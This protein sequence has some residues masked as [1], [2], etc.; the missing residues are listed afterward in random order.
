[1]MRRKICFFFFFR[2]RQDTEQ[3]KRHAYRLRGDRIF[4]SNRILRLI[5]RWT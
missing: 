4:E 3:V 5:I 1:M 2:I